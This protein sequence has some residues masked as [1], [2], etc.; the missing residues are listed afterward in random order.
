MY[1]TLG[2][3]KTNRSEENEGEDDYYKDH[4]KFH[5]ELGSSNLVNRI[6]M[7]LT[8][9]EPYQAE[10][11]PSAVATNGI[12]G[13]FG[14]INNGSLF[15]GELNYEFNNYSGEKDGLKSSGKD[16]SLWLIGSFSFPI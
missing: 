14:V 1:G 16:S 12:G 4:N 7:I 15:Q 2:I 11:S 5:L 3:K 6:A 9:I 8:Y 10:D 13:V